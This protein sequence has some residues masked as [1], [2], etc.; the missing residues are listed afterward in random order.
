MSEFREMF[1]QALAEV[2]AGRNRVH[3]I[4]SAG[5]WIVKREGA[6]RASNVFK[7]KKDAVQRAASLAKGIKGE[8]IVHDHSGRIAFQKKS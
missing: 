6:Q 3:V 5:R 7:V 4:P 2:P 8:I 1:A